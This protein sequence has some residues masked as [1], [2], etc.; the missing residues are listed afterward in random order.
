MSV[1]P[2][3]LVYV[4]V[5]VGGVVRSTDNGRSWTPTIDVHA[6][7]HEVLVDPISG[8]VLAASAHGLAVSRNQG[9]SWRFETGG[10]H[11]RYLRAVTV[12]GET[13]LISASTGPFTKRAA[14][15]RRPAHGDKS[16]ERCQRGLPAWFSENINTACLAASGS[17]VVFGTSTGEVF[18]SADEGQSW[19]L[20]AEG[21]PP[22]RCVTL[23]EPNAKV[24][25]A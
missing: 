14:V 25:E 13:I 5:H 1:D 15:Y 4:N 19:C 2:S 9:E 21:L 20:L 23:M 17:W 12:A 11:G 6:D 3:G 8:L 10:L 18:L 22:V 7:V 24:E 16:F